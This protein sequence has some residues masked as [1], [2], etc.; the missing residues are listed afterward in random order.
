MVDLVNVEKI[1]LHALN[2]YQFACLDVLRFK[3]FGK[4]PVSFFL[5]KAVFFH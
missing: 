3:N 5:N 4:C 2:G 1:S